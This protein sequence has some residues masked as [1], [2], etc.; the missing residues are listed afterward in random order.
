MDVVPKCDRDPRRGP[1]DG[2]Q[3]Q[4]PRRPDPEQP[5]DRDRAWAG[6]DQRRRDRQIRQRKLGA[7]LTDPDGLVA[8]C[9]APG[10]DHRGRR[11]D[12]ADRRKEPERSESATRNLRPA[13]HLRPLLGGLEAHPLEA[14]RRSFDAL[15]AE[16]TKKLLRT[17]TYQKATRHQAQQ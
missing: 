1:N 12:R 3:G 5:I 4:P 9:L 8:V 10:D 11:D 16:R 7:A 14:L 13:R 2:E 17:V 15:A 6:E